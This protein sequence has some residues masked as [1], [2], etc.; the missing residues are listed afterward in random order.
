MGFRSLGRSDYGEKNHF[1]TK[2]YGSFSTTLISGEIQLFSEYIID[3]NATYI[4]KL[5]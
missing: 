3:R 1:I 4:A 5:I 2:L